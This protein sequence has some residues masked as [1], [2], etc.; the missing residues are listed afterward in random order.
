MSSQGYG[1]LQGFRFDFIKI[2]LGCA[3]WSGK[4]RFDSDCLEFY[5][6]LLQ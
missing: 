5:P 2:T 6:A 3:T 1:T 4:T